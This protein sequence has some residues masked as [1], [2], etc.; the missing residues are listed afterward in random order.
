MKETTAL[1]AQISTEVNTSVS[2][3]PRGSKEGMNMITD[4][5]NSMI[6][7][8]TIHKFNKFMEK[9]N[10]EK[11]YKI[12]T[13]LDAKGE[14]I[15]S[16]ILSLMYRNGDYVPQD[17]Y[18]EVL[19][20]EKAAALGFEPAIFSLATG[21]GAYT[22]IALDT[23][24]SMNMM[25]ELADGGYAPAVEIMLPVLQGKDYNS[26]HL[27]KELEAQKVLEDRSRCPY[28]VS[29]KEYIGTDF[30]FMKQCSM[31]DHEPVTEEDGIIMLYV[32]SLDYLIHAFMLF[33][34]KTDFE[35]Q[36]KFVSGYDAW[37]LAWDRFGES[38]HWRYVERDLNREVRVHQALAKKGY[39]PAIFRLAL[40]CIF[41]MGTEQD[42]DFGYA[43]ML[44]LANRGYRDAIEL[45]DKVVLENIAKATAQEGKE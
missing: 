40:A 13:K 28:K 44:D 34:D 5:T 43:V 20:L 42:I 16:Y 29:D 37:E 24:K 7:E 9:G 11:A 41:G 19:Y 17:F 4:N 6:I 33:V 8:K 25:S 18:K 14:A 35:T 22:S 26:N 23:V 10:I 2:K 1:E 32:K 15:G 38:Y 31:T 27:A 36:D 45:L 30:R 12:A 3:T 39:V 21:D